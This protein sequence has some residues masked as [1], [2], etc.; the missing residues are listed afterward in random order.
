MPKAAFDIGAVE[1]RLPLRKIAS[2]A[3]DICAADQAEAS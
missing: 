2:A 3:L 1:R